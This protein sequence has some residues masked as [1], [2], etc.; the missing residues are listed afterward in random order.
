MSKDEIKGLFEQFYKDMEEYS[1]NKE[2]VLNEMKYFL[3]I[4]PNGQ[5][6]KL[7]VLKA[8]QFEKGTMIG[9]DV[10]LENM[11]GLHTELYLQRKIA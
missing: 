11:A 1:V 3:D 4:S 5:D 10:K 6:V 7:E 8:T 9:V 2:E